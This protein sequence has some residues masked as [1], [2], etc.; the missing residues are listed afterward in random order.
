MV[1]ETFISIVALAVCVL[2]WIPLIK[3]FVKTIKSICNKLKVKKV[4]ES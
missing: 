1:I 2:V 3:D 4:N